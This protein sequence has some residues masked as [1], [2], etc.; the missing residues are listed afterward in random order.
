MS[1]QI[2]LFN[3]VF[4]QQKKI[5]SARTM[6]AALLVL[7]AGVA[8]L[9]AYGNMRV[10]DLQRQAD[11]GAAQLTQKQ[12]R[13]DSVAKEFAPRQKNPA[14]EAE[15]AEAEG[16]L[17]AL[18]EVSGVLARGELGNTQGYA[19]Y[20]RALARQHVDGLWLTGVSIS[21]AG[22]DIGVRGRALDPQRVPGYLNRLTSEPVMRGKAFGSLS[23]NQGGGA[24]RV[25]ENGKT[26]AQAAPYVEF[27]L[28]SAPE[29]VKP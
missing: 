18:R 20:F 12:A 3:P 21:G 27:S 25:D 29:G 11:A 13:L 23:I 26:V 15:L 22:V 16:Q 8:A 10:R 6:G 24:A 17:A 2:N 28:L 5:F 14:V 7:F 1:Q 9:G 19:E 4:L